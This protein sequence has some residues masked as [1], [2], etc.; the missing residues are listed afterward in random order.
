MNSTIFFIAFYCDR[1]DHLIFATVHLTVEIFLG[2]HYAYMHQDLTVGVLIKD[3]LMILAYFVCTSVFGMA[4]IYTDDLRNT[5]IDT[6]KENVK[7]L[8]GMHE[9]LVVLQKRW[10]P[11]D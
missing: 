3:I 4:F 1:L 6:N 9:G 5:V 8:N 10:N 7:L 2:C 11:N